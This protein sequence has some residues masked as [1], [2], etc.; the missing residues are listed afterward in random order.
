MPAR[1]TYRHQWLFAPQGDS[2]DA[3]DS[4]EVQDVQGVGDQ[5]V[6]S[7]HG[8]CECGDC[9]SGW[10]YRWSEWMAGR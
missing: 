8:E 2:R 5:A 10:S 6:T 7:G 3:A 9:E 1:W 4:Q